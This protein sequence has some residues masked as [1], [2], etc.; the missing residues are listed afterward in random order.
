MPLTTSSARVLWGRR[1]MA[2]GLVIALP[3]MCL[4]I[5]LLHIGMTIAFVGCAIAW[6]ALH[7][8]PGFWIGVAFAAW[9]LIGALV[10]EQGSTHGTI[11]TWLG[12]YVCAA[13]L[14][15]PKA[16]RWALMTMLV[17]LS[18]A[19]ALQ[20]VQFTVGHGGDRPFRVSAE[21]KPFRTSS[22]FMPLHLT[23]G[24]VL[25]QALLLSLMGSAQ[26]GLAPWQLM[27][28]RILATAGVLIAN[29]RT[30]LLAMVAA[31]VARFAVGGGAR[32]LLWSAGLMVAGLALVLA[33]V[34][35]L[36]PKRIDKALAGNDGRI[37]HWQVAAEVIRDHPWFGTGEGPNFRREYDRVLAQRYPDGSQN[38]WLQTP[39][40]HNF[41]LGLCSE[42]GIPALLLYVLMLGA[43][44][45]HLWRRR[46]E[47]PQG[48]A[49]GCG[50]LASML[51]GG[52]F[53]QY[54]GHT[55]TSYAFFLAL[56]AALA[57]DSDETARCVGWEPTAAPTAP[58]GAAAAPAAA[59][60]GAA[61]TPA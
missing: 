13:T 58:E 26:A 56:G 10:T 33:W 4:S 42:H 29:S 24:F 30:A 6:P 16:R 18:A 15:E 19:V 39:D 40:A 54:A 44:L 1:L 61:T 35:V 53:E 36:T 12:I 46:A 7:R 9:Q 41:I 27:A 3:A 8:L 55:T 28:A 37:I 25:T 34:W 22:G 43:V 21:A 47:N 59:E 23:Q 52:E 14:L 60:G 57:L 2:L 51:V 17:A 38:R 31:V 48:F 32:R 11:F 5:A 50:A 20:V 49:L 45:R